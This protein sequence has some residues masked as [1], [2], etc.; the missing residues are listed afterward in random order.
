M[1][2]WKKE[3]LQYIKYMHPSWDD[4]QIQ[5]KVRQDTVLFDQYDSKQWKIQDQQLKMYN[6]CVQNL[7]ETSRGGN[8]LLK[9][10]RCVKS[11]MSSDVTWTTLQTRSAD[12]GSTI[13]CT[14]NTCKH[15]WKLG[16]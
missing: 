9:C 6:M 11:G 2:R 3:Q 13:F 12:E 1:N 14:C 16:S 7:T 5:K 10:N 8:Q 15:R 4:A